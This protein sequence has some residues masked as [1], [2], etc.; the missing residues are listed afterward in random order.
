[1]CLVPLPPS[2]TPSPDLADRDRCAASVFTSFTYYQVSTT[3]NDLSHNGS[4]RYHIDYLPSNTSD[5]I[6]RAQDDGL[7]FAVDS[8]TIIH[9]STLLS[10]LCALQ[11]PNSQDPAEPKVV[12]LPG[13]TGA[14]IR[15]FLLLASDTDQRSI[16]HVVGYVVKSDPPITFNLVQD[17]LTLGD[18]C[19]IVNITSLLIRT[20]QHEIWLQ[21]A[22]CALTG[23]SHFAQKIAAKTIWYDITQVPV[24]A[25]YILENHVLTEYVWLI[26]FWQS[27]RADLAERLQW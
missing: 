20:F 12:D 25:K 11:Y 24:N 15:A 13:S 6:L 14:A 2:R 4:W 5:M 1:M 3:D 8:A 16:G 10:D 19:D 21:F 22:I 26:E 23:E 7:C 9:H 27:S 17:V 18:A